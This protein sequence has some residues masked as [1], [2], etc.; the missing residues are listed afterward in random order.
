M[1][2]S[3]LEEFRDAVGNRARSCGKRP[4]NTS[5]ESPKTIGRP[6]LPMAASKEWGPD[7]DAPTRL[8][9]GACFQK[10]VCIQM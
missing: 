5:M 9:L 1:T 6:Q 2:D 8:L 7:P 4:Q 10:T 3:T